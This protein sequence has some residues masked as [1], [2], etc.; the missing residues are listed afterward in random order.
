MNFSLTEQARFFNGFGAEYLD[1]KPSYK[2]FMKKGTPPKWCRDRLVDVQHIRLEI[3]PDFKTRSISGTSTLT[4]A[5]IYDDT[6]FMVLDACEMEIEGVSVDGKALDF[7]HDGENLTVY[8]GRKLDADKHIELAVK[9]SATPKRGAY[10]VGPDS[11]YPNKHTEFWTQGQDEDS[12]YWF[13]CFDYPNEKLTSEIIARVPKGMTSLSNGALIDE[14]ED[15]DHA[16]HHWKHDVPH[17]PYLMMLVIGN[18]VKVSEEWDGIPVDYY[19]PPGREE[20]GERSFGPTPD[21]VK[22]FSE[23]T[24]VRY[25]YAK[26]AQITAEDFIFGGM[27]N[28][29][30]TLQTSLT[31]HDARAHLDF[32][33]DPLNSHELAHQWFG[34]YVTC[35]D[36]SHAWLNESFA[37]YFEAMWCEE[38]LGD[39]EFKYYLDAD[40]RAYLA[41]D[42]GAY[43]RAIQTNIYVEPLDLFDRHLYQ[44]GAVILHHLRK[45]LGDRLWWKVINRYLTKHGGGN[46]ITQDFASAIEDVTGK[47]YDWFFSQWIYGGGHPEFKVKA[48]WDDK[49]TSLDFSI[50]QKQKQ[51][52]LTAIFRTPVKVRFVYSGGEETREFEIEKPAHRYHIKLP[53]RPKWIAFDPGNAVPKTLELEYSEEMLIS[54]LAHD[55]DVMGRVHAARALANKPTKKSTEALAKALAE[56][57]FWGVQAEAAAALGKI[58]SK[59]ALNALLENSQIKH[60]KARRA[61]VRAL[62]EFRDGRATAT[63]AAKLQ[64]DE[65]Y[66]VAAE[67]GLAI[68]KTRGS[69][70]YDVMVEALAQESHNDVIRAHIF[71]GFCELRDMRALEVLKEWCVYGKPQQARFAAIAALGR[72]AQESTEDKDKTE[73]REILEQCLEGDF[74]T[75]MSAISGLT[76]LKEIKAL[77]ALAKLARSSPDSR[78]KKRAKE[79]IESIRAAQG[80]NKEVKSLREDYDKL[81]ES[82]EKFKE[83]LDK[84]E[85]LESEKKKPRHTE[86][87]KKTAKLTTKVAAKKTAKKSTARRSKSL[88]NNSGRKTAAKP[89]AKKAVKGKAKRR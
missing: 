15:G 47:N 34:D 7:N 8:F 85:D 5:P 89:N 31:L 10:F 38:S 57:K 24:G 52:D 78:I 61:V 35:R 33:S 36:W 9:Y 41:E 18:Y 12:R 3:A 29:T 40:W 60:P 83:R 76:A 32:S 48:R 11:G 66:Y 54:Q 6:D 75:V 28:T 1:A 74:R 50:L 84:L 46:V 23:K 80:T 58:H 72:L 82:Y 39:D 27:E 43:R 65:S 42:K 21:M 45:Q 56:D 37:T 14:R 73:A 51:D 2:P 63:L 13:P 44:K 25:P 69:V 71:S 17:V 77:P 62:G 86:S 20:D 4:V 64:K 16:I 79:A 88:K 70:A 30:A 19:V 59:A 87:V 53:S 68:A 67:A 26:Y 49:T 81:K 55:D 22:F